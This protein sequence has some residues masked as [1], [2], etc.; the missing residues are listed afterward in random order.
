MTKKSW[1]QNTSGQPAPSETVTYYKTTKNVN[2]LFKW[3]SSKS[4]QTN[5]NFQNGSP[6]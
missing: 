3:Y 2:M 4:V 5:R 1:E 6:L